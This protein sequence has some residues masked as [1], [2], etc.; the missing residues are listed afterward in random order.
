MVLGQR[1]KNR[2]MSM[3]STTG[4]SN[5]IAEIKEASSEAGDLNQE[6]LEEGGAEMATLHSIL[7]SPVYET[8]NNQSQQHL[9]GDQQAS[10]ELSP[11]L[12]VA[13]KGS[14]TSAERGDVEGVVVVVGEKK[15]GGGGGPG[16]PSTAAS[17]SKSKTAIL[18]NIFFSQIASSS[19]SSSPT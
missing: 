15:A 17:A 13:S 2:N 7:I 4:S 14:S 1:M 16:S 10:I 5:Y 3:E 9:E 12:S 18:R 8:E 19:S 11:S 6:A